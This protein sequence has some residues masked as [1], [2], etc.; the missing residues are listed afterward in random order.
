MRSD[1]VKKDFITNIVAYSIHAPQGKKNEN[2][3]LAKKKF[4]VMSKLKFIFLTLTV[5][6]V[7]LAGILYHIFYQQKSKSDS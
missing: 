7:N 4:C 3:N 2:N 1:I 5:G 6:F